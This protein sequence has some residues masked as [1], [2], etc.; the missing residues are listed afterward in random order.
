[1]VKGL[2]KRS[3]QPLAVLMYS[4]HMISTPNSAAKLAP[5][6]GG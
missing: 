3:S 6:S 1:M 2:T 4:F 5:A